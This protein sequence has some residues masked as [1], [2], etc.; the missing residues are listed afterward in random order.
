MRPKASFMF[1]VAD[2]C[3]YTAVWEGRALYSQRG[4][5]MTKKSMQS[6]SSST[7]P[8]SSER[9]LFICGRTSAA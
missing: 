1:Q 9:K 5:D 6:S 2:I 7:V 8:H 4:A 3:R